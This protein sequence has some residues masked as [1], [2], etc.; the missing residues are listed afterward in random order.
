MVDLF[1]GQVI[2][3]D[4]I[5]SNLINLGSSNHY[6]QYSHCM[7]RVP[8]VFAPSMLRESRDV[9]SY[10]SEVQSYE[11]PVMSSPEEGDIA[12]STLPG[13]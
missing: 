10:E 13:L 4:Q 11:A 8:Y 7:S 1:Q 9:L 12:Y 2:L 5:T 6:Y 3:D